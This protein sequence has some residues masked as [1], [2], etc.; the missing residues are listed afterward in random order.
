MSVI[1]LTKQK[2]QDNETTQLL[3]R[4]IERDIPT[5]VCYFKN[6]DIVTNHGIFYDSQPLKLP[7]I[8]LVRLGAGIS[9]AELAIIRYFELAGVKCINSS[10]SIDIVQD[11]FQTSEILSNNGV[12]VPTSMIAK[13]PSDIT[14]VESTIGFPCI[15]K[16]VVGSFGE[17]IYLCHSKQEY[18][19]IIEFAEAL[20]NEKT[21]IVQE[22]IGQRPG[23]DL[24]V[25]IINGKVLGAM[26]RTAP[27]GDFRAN[28]SHGGTGESFPVTPE[29]EEI[30][31]KTASL[32]KLDIAGIDLLFD[33]RGFRVC[34]ANSNPGF[35]GFNKYCNADVATVIADYIQEELHTT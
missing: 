34:E 1:I 14:L 11:K 26:K 28:I 13:F 18:I 8:V 12:P 16:V 10:K 31:L 15:V 32:L 25:F 35:A 29:I 4:F 23:E 9:R 5:R 19:N 3:L 2:E 27:A 24:R 22:Y 7:K 17:G 20:H 21:L 33:P 6:F 30:A